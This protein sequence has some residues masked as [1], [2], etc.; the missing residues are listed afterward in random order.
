MVSITGTYREVF[1]IVTD[2]YL[3]VEGKQCLYRVRVVFVMHS[4]DNVGHCWKFS[5]LCHI[6][7]WTQLSALGHGHS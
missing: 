6:G 4:P 3:L 5:E 1:R 7:T 2:I